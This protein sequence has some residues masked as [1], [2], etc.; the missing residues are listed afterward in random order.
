MC[1]QWRICRPETKLRTSD[2]HEKLMKITILQNLSPGWGFFFGAIPGIVFIFINMWI[3][4]RLSKRVR[5]LALAE[6]QDWHVKR[7]F[8]QLIRAL[9]DPNQILCPGESKGLADIKKILIKEQWRFMAKH[10]FGGLLIALGG[11]V[12]TVL[13]VYVQDQFNADSERKISSALS[14]HLM[15][16]IACGRDGADRRRPRRRNLFPHRARDTRHAGGNRAP[17]ARHWPQGAL[18]QP[19]DT[20]IPRADACHG[21]LALDG[22]GPHGAVRGRGGRPSRYRPHLRDRTAHRSATTYIR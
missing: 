18:S 11:T 13:G 17:V 10:L 2:I 20:G 15:G 9:E 4:A 1:V 22:Q 7:D 16:E 3:F 8:V 5:A 12:G 21:Q 6:G 19:T 14:N